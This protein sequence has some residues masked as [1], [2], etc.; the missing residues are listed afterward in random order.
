MGNKQ[1]LPN[2]KKIK[3]EH[4]VINYLDGDRYEGETYNNKKSGFGIYY[5][6][7]SKNILVNGKMENKMELELYIIN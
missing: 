3:K 6:Y 2:M 1:E 7:K 5:F 4:Q